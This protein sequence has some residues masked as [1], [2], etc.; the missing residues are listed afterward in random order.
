M[1]RLC[2]E[3]QTLWLPLSGAGDP[4]LSTLGEGL[5]AA[6]LSPRG[7]GPGGGGGGCVGRGRPSEV[8]GRREGTLRG[9]LC[10]L[11]GPSQPASL[12]DCTPPPLASAAIGRQ[13]WLESGRTGPTRGSGL[14]C[15]EC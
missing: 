8:L 10:A 14:W 13:A 5:R 1:P 3:I 15:R 12:P 7:S 9:A 11:W 4:S 2:P 6:R